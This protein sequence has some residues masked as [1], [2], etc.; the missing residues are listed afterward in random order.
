MS[1]EDKEYDSLHEVAVDDLYYYTYLCLK[2]G[3]DLYGT[4]EKYIVRDF[5]E[6]HIVLENKDINETVKEAVLK[7]ISNG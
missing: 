5:G 3:G 4:L 6:Y 1:N 2:E 7:W